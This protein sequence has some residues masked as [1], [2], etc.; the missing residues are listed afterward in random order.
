MA[1][2][3]PRM[4][5]R[6][7]T[8]HLRV[9]VPEALRP[10]VGKVEFRK[11]L[12]TSNLAEARRLLPLELV[13]VDAEIAAAR[14]KLA[15]KPVSTLSRSEME[16]LA[17]ELFHKREAKRLAAAP[18]GPDALTHHE[19]DADLADFLDALRDPKDEE[20]EN[21]VGNAARRL[22]ADN[23]VALDTKS[24][25]WREFSGLVRRAYLE[26]ARR[27]LKEHRA[28]HS[29][30]PGDALFAVVEGSKPIPPSAAPVTLEELLKRWRATPNQKAHS[31]KSKLKAA[32]QDRLFLEVFGKGTPITSISRPNAARLV[33]LLA[34][35][36]ANAAKRWPKATSIE[37]A[38]LAA[39][40]GVEPMARLTARSYLTAFHTMFEHA[41]QCGHVEIN[42]VTGLSVGTDRIAARDR[43]HPFSKDQLRAIFRAPLY[44]GCR[45]DAHGYA[46]PG[47]A[48][49]RRGRFWVPLLSLLHGLRLQEACQLHVADVTKLDGVDVILIR[50]AGEDGED[51]D[52]RV[53]TA[54]GE[55]FVPV[56]PEAVRIGFLAYVETMRQRGEVRLF[57]DLEAAKASGYLSDVFSKWFARFLDKAGAKRPR[58]AFHSFRH[59]YRDALREADISAERVRA[60]G[61]WSSGS[62]E[63][64]YGSGPRAST[65]A[66][67]MAKVEFPVDLKHLYAR[68]HQPIA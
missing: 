9:K 58:T 19:A 64:A 35:L 47:D 45:D 8:W 31:P 32:A 18:G 43:R 26:S 61:G 2:R 51:S 24:R 13:K 67:D 29:A 10:L 21:I 4:I 22:L 12:K 63:D 25:E 48:K 20:A 37:A 40:A 52:K 30:A 7:N 62:T 27:S 55:R 54:A 39:E 59:S 28:D 34:R 41:R 1:K 3:D 11:S 5:L 14:R 60:L 57:P 49:P 65:L 46:I 56:H 38:D 50:A 42:P 68:P 36:P 53:K 33:D 16:H 66:A 17:V 23:A 6:G 44:T 15:A